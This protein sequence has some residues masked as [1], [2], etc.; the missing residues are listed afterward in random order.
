MLADQATVLPGSIV[1]SCSEV[2]DA[3]Q[4]NKRGLVKDGEYI[5]STI[6]GRFNLRDFFITSATGSKIPKIGDVVICQVLRISSKVA[7][8]SILSS[9]KECFYPATFKGT[10]RSQDVRATE[11]DRVLIHES[12]RP[13]DILIA[14]VLGNGDSATGFLLSTAKNELGVLVARSIQSDSIMIPI[15]WDSMQCPVSKSVE[16]R[17][18]AKLQ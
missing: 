1:C 15:S 4:F 8:V 6:S 9:E 7:K 13:A 5:Y 12:F 11:R 16:R 2:S 3:T 17:K 18:C 10:I 14:E